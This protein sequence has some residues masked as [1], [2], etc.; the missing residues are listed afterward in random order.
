VRLKRS[1]LNPCPQCH[2]RKWLDWKID[3]G[4]ARYKDMFAIQCVACD[5]RAKLVYSTG[6]ALEG[7][8]AFAIKTKETNK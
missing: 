3:Y 6:E 1:T 2:E 4:G 8:N 5:L 7:W